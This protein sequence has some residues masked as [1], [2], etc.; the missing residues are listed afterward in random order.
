MMKHMKVGLTSMWDRLRYIRQR[1][2]Q[3]YILLLIYYSASFSAI[4]SHKLILIQTGVV[5]TANPDGS[6]RLHYLTDREAQMMFQQQQAQIASL[7]SIP[8]YILQNLFSHFQF[9]G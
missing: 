9:F 4:F 8:Y 1:C 2:V 3:V 5:I 7:I 6:Q